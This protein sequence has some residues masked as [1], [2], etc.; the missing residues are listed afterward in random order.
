TILISIYFAAEYILVMS[1]EEQS[2]YLYGLRHEPYPWQQDLINTTF[3]ILQ[4]IY[5]SLA[6]VEVY[7]YKKRVKERL[8]SLDKIK[9]RYAIRFIILI[10]LLNLIAIVLY[11]TLPMA[12]VEYFALPLVAAP[13]Y[14]FIIYFAFHYNSI[15]TPET[16][17]QFLID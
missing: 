1:P 8:S 14:I 11:T 10:W 3:V 7:R 5:F 16:Y 6:A 12:T 15:F 4:L 13:I 2:Q 17:N 9:I